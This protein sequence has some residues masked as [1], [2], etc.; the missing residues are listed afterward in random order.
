MGPFFPSTESL[1]DN[2]RIN[3]AIGENYTISA[4]FQ[5]LLLRFKKQYLSDSDPSNAQPITKE[6]RGYREDMTLCQFLI[7][8]TNIFLYA[9][10]RRETPNQWFQ[11][12][13]HVLQDF[14]ST[15]KRATMVEEKTETQLGLIHP[16]FTQSNLTLICFTSWGFWVFLFKNNSTRHHTI[17]S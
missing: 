10:K 5:L 11:I 8:K 14:S 17:F 1:A 6:E 7:N 13:F 9:W 16:L 15:S 3:C 2:W 12:Q 4:L